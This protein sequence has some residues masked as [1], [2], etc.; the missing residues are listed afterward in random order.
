MRSRLAVK[1]I[2]CGSPRPQLANVSAI[3][4]SDVTLTIQ[5]ITRHA[6]WG[7]HACSVPVAACCGNE[8][9]FLRESVAAR[10]RMEVREG[11]MPSP[12]RYKRALPKLPRTRAA[13][14]ALIF[15]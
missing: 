9:F 7:A 5:H 13:F 2:V 1:S 12:A 14:I 6:A 4:T 8:L 3:K 10:T 11:R 15:L